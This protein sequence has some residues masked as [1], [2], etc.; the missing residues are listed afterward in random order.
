[1]QPKVLIIVLTFNGIDLTIDCLRSLQ[2][3]HYQNVTTMVVDNASVD[4]T[5]QIVRENFPA[6]QVIETGANLG[7]AE[8]NNV[9]MRYAMANGY[10]YVLLLNNDTEV[11]PN[12]LDQLVTVCESNAAVGVV[13]PKVLYHSHPDLIYSAGG[14]VDWK[15]GK[16]AMI[17]IN[18]QDDGRFDTPIEVDFINGCA[19]LVRTA[20]M[21]DGGLLD[22]RFGMYFEEVEWCVRLARHGWHVCYA[23]DS[24]VWHK[25][26]PAQ[27]A[28]LPRITYYMTRNRLLFL[29]LTHAPLR[30]WLHASLLQDWRTWL[31]WGV[32]AKWQ[33]RAAHR[34][35]IVRG[36]HDF[37][38]GR[39]GMSEL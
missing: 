39:Y 23:P 30:P 26:D 7:Y 21:H 14:T 25:I 29:K 36:W 11:A 38:R 13:G 8:G 9:G 31:S 32:R 5:P 3:I 12:F 19:I 1:M 22:A 16:T 17:G 18:Q 4:G 27:R 2:Q 24:V 28:E 10:D 6:V 20:A 37:L 15:R 34:T 35:Q 33:G